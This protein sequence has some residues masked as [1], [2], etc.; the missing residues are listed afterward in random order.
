[1]SIPPTA[2]PLQLSDIANVQDL[3]TQI[4]NTELTR[5]QQKQDGLNNERDTRRRNIKINQSYVRRMRQYAYMVG[6]IVISL[7]ICAILAAMNSVFPLS[8]FNIA[9][10]IVIAVGAVWSYYIYIDIQKHDLLDFDQ[11]SDKS[12]INPVPLITT[13]TA[14]NILSGKTGTGVLITSPVAACIGSDCCSDNA[15]TVW[16]STLLK[17]T[18]KP[19]APIKAPFVTLS[20][21]VHVDNTSYSPN[22]VT[23]I[24]SMF[25]QK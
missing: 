20:G 19:V 18:L 7:T 15:G 13:T 14:S 5:V 16:D 12:L 4:I 25:T 24:K 8:I 2:T 6:V 21:N 3:S 11:V 23:N 1:M 9:T 10:V 22:I 17:C